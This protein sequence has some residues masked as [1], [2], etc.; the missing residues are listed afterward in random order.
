MVDNS[1]LL[2]SESD[3]PSAIISSI[4]RNRLKLVLVAS[5][6]I[7]IMLAY[8]IGLLAIGYAGGHGSNRAIALVLAAVAAGTWAIR[9]QGLLLSRVSSVRILELTRIARAV[10]IL[11]ALVVLIDRVGRF[12]F[13]IHDMVL[14][15][16]LA[17]VFLCASRSFYRGWVAT[18]REHGAH[19]RRIVL[20]GID[21]EAVRLNQLFETHREIGSQVV[22]VIGDR[23]TAA[24]N[25]LDALWLGDVDRAEALVD[26][27]G[28]SG[29]VVSAGGVPIAQLNAIVR[30]LVGKGIHVHL[31]TGISGIDARRLRST[32]IAHEPL[33]YIEAPSLGKTQLLAKRIMD[34]VLSSCALVVLSPLLALV[35]VL[36]KLDD[37][38]P[39]LFRQVR[40]G[41]S[42]QLF[43]V[44]KFRTMTVGAERQLDKLQGANE[45]NG[46]LFKMVD[47]P[48]VTGVGRFLRTSGLDELPQLINVVRGQMSLVGPRPALPTEVELF[49]VELRA[50]DQV[51]PGI[52]G[53]WQ[54]EARDNPSFEAYRRLDL[55]YVEN[56]ST[57]LDL[58][59]ILATIEQFVSRL[60]QVVLRKGHR[61]LS[62]VIAV[63][64]DSASAAASPETFDV[65]S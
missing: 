8:T 1:K 44:L 32:P 64:V 27:V 51:T 58:M 12:D 33:L 57:T 40:V 10:G 4:Q 65:A 56:W 36:I 30:T 46:P 43:G 3:G 49:P 22:G 42:G 19:V 13:A 24:A 2:N 37:R 16:M 54:V 61:K 21:A 39:I 62:E 41:K 6:A 53:L 14:P 48:R 23:E 63:S 29:V 11:A 45:R 5:D 20:I 18:S 9:S 59:I 34:V 28:A 17:L 25:G 55:F 26:H 50:R 15:S 47:D 52:S 38:G 7:A 60:L 35:A 31:A